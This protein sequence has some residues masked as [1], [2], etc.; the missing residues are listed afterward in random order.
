MRYFVFL[1]GGSAL[2]QYICHKTCDVRQYISLHKVRIRYVYTRKK[3]LD[4][5]PLGCF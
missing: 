2:F 3:Q 5:L 4:E 1:F